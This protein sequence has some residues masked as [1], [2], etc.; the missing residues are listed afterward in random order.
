M[1]NSGNYKK[2]AKNTF[3]LY[4]RM[5]I[6]MLFSLYTSRLLLQILGF[7]NYG[8][9]N[10]VGGIVVLFSFLNTALSGATQRFLSYSLGN[11]S[12]EDKTKQVFSVALT[13]HIIIAIILLILA[14]TVG[15]WFF[16]EKLNIPEARFNAAMIAYQFSVFVTIINIIRVPYN[17]III[18]YEKMD[19]FAYLSIAECLIKFIPIIIIP[20][21]S[22]DELIIYAFLLAI[23][24]AVIYIIYYFY[25]KKTIPTARFSLQFDKE[26]FKAMVSFTGWHTISGIANMT[27]NQGLNIII[28]MF[29]GVVVNA[30]VGIANQVSS[31]V[32]Q[33]MGNFLVAYSPQLTK[34]YANREY[35]ELYKIINF[36]SKISF[37]LLS[38]LSIP[39]IVNI[40]DIFTLW[41]TNYPPYAAELTICLLLANVLDGFSAPLW[42]AI[43]ATGKVK[44][45]AILLS[46]GWIA[47][48]PVSYLLLD[49]G[50]SPVYCYSLS[51][52]INGLMIFI[53][54]YLLKRYIDF[55]VKYFLTDVV[56]KGI[57]FFIISYVISEFAIIQSDNLLIRL[58]GSVSLSVIITV[59]TCYMICFN[60]IER[61]KIKCIIKQKF[62]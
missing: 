32:N 22:F 39:L 17:A 9:Y 54:L 46:I 40:E 59:L 29:L 12:S 7:E 33:F 44:V 34:S 20:A 43:S 26:T 14:E 28:N 1:Q 19:F 52:Y 45:Y 62:I 5:G 60:T 47:I 56:C 41:L 4:I 2:I 57:V 23:A 24:N 21:I 27:R 50:F 16:Y 51:I 3:L 13:L 49:N 36:S 53:R 11:Q 35:Q 30:A 25:C 48:L 15:L 61:N 31:Q 55:P 58:F 38:V 37:I 42:T 6:L 10:L 18:S 8:I